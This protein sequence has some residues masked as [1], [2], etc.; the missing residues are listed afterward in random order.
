[1]PKYCVEFVAD[2]CT[3]PSRDTSDCSDC[4]T[5]HIS[6]ENNS[7]TLPIKSDS[8]LTYH[9]STG[10]NI[11][12]QKSNSSNL[13]YLT[14]DLNK[15]YSEEDNITPGATKVKI[16][17]SKCNTNSHELSMGN[18][19]CCMPD[20]LKSTCE[21]HCQKPNF[22][23]H[24][25]RSQNYASN[26]RKFVISRAVQYEE[27]SEKLQTRKEMTM[28]N[29]HSYQEILCN[30]QHQHHYQYNGSSIHEKYDPNK[31]LK[32]DIP[33]KIADKASQCQWDRKQ[34]KISTSHYLSK[35]GIHDDEAF[36]PCVDI[37]TNHS[38]NLLNS[39]S[40]W[41]VDV[42]SLSGQR[43]SSVTPPIRMIESNS[44]FEG[45]PHGDCYRKAE[46]TS[47]DENHEMVKDSTDC[48]DNCDTGSLSA[49][50]P[51]K[52]INPLTYEGECEDKMK[53]QSSVFDNSNYYN[54]NNSSG[55]NSSYTKDNGQCKRSKSSTGDLR[56][57]GEQRQENK[58][59]IPCPNYYVPLTDV[60]AFG[61]S[62]HPLT[63]STIKQNQKCLISTGSQKPN[64]HIH[65]SK[66]QCHPSESYYIPGPQVEISSHIDL[67]GGSFT[68]A[69]SVSS[70]EQINLNNE[71]EIIKSTLQNCPT[72][73]PSHIQQG[74]NTNQVSIDSLPKEQP[75]LNA[76]KSEEGSLNQPKHEEFDKS[77][78][79]GLNSQKTSNGSST[80][81]ITPKICEKPVNLKSNVHE[82]VGKQ[83]TPKSNLPNS[84]KN[85][86]L[87]STY[88]NS[89][90][91]QSN[92]ISNKPKDSKSSPDTKN[93]Q[94]FVPSSRP[95]KESRI[96]I[97]KTILPSPIYRPPSIQKIE[98]NTHQLKANQSIKTTDLR[99]DTMDQSG[100]LQRNYDAAETLPFDIKTDPHL[101]EVNSS[102][103][104]NSNMDNSVEAN[105]IKID[106]NEKPE[107][108]K[109]SL[110]KRQSRSL[111]KV[112]YPRDNS[113]IQ[114]TKSHHSRIRRKRQSYSLQPRYFRGTYYKSNS[115]NN[116]DDDDD[117]GNF[118]N[119][120][121]TAHSR[122]RSKFLATKSLTP[123]TSQ[124]WD[125][126]PIAQNVHTKSLMIQSGF[127]YSDLKPPELLL[128]VNSISTINYSDTSNDLKV[129]LINQS[130]R[131]TMSSPPTNLPVLHRR[132]SNESISSAPLQKPIS[133]PLTASREP[134][135]AN[136]SPFTSINNPSQALTPPTPIPSSRIKLIRRKFFIPESA[137]IEE[138]LADPDDRRIKAICE[139]Y[140]CDLEI[141]SKLPWCG[142]LQYVIIMSARDIY[143]LRRCA[144]TLDSRL[145]WCLSAQLK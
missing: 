89:T 100:I 47:K 123:P 112:I 60:S 94:I 37:L 9:I 46:Y 114:S 35:T 58:N 143:T 39:V 26:C 6:L 27:Q 140:K 86:L 145:N 113:T 14:K 91:H 32:S 108:V 99:A 25:T 30:H 136:L 124:A 68:N 103:Q 22:D 74:L 18:T 56:Q 105:T 111:E 23:R 109:S 11:P 31:N 76:E 2:V 13:E 21:Y 53:C 8:I 63:S 75:H 102:S 70:L 49:T 41:S 97:P 101:A 59:R 130:N 134:I 67:S 98:L 48:N 5:E 106:D 142:F 131:S 84:F 38:N 29:N 64:H 110:Q 80:N 1:M 127:D 61:D 34:T 17:N 115:N 90:T 54:H 57:S 129:Q 121:R 72:T 62:L 82:H 96:P 118:K 50:F 125:K 107:N 3:V 141:Y 81:K 139:R 66:H 93:T 10:S 116:D 20:N 120:T 42:S 44:K 83:Y 73:T 104:T 16:S 45:I 133:R 126:N 24:L 138:I 77:L 137:N 40:E 79:P 33:V 43:C 7:Y 144:R 95:L 119:R 36:L 132:L 65:N 12:K 87:N 55:S 71:H 88:V 28:S 52:S 51:S 128:Q 69:S 117:N 4:K 78:T 122:P 85:T 135:A 19:V 92:D 15:L